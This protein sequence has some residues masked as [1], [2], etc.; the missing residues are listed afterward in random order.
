MALVNGTL[1]TEPVVE[2]LLE[3]TSLAMIQSKI[4]M[5]QLL[6]MVVGP[7]PL[8]Q[9]VKESIGESAVEALKA[10]MNSGNEEGEGEVPQTEAE[11]EDNDDGIVEEISTADEGNAA[12]ET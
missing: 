5:H 11:G 1:G 3:N 2:I 8:S 6:N 4:F 9:S 10:A 12:E 7:R